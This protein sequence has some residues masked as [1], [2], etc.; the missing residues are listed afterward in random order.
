MQLIEMFLETLLGKRWVKSAEMEAC[1]S[2]YQSFVQ[3][4]KQLERTSTRSRPDV[5]NVLI[6]CSS[7][8]GFRVRRHLYKL[9]IVS[10][11]RGFILLQLPAPSCFVSGLSINSTCHSWTSDIW[12]EVYG[13]LGSGGCQGGRSARC[14]VIF[15]KFCERSCFQP[16]QLLLRGECRNAI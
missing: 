2:E 16:T 11:N 6:F 4:Q 3:E 14:P 7:Q 15:S 10:K 5:G 8:V 9:S 1:K 13:Q 12:R